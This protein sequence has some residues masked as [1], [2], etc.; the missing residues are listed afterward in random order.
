MI[1]QNKKLSSSQELS[2]RY[3]MNFIK[4]IPITLVKGEGTHVWDENGKEYIDFVGGWAVDSLGHCH[5]VMKKAIAEQANLLFQ[6]SNHY[7]TIPQAQLAEMLVKNSC[8]H[9]AFF[10]NS[11]TE[12][13]EGAVKLAR[14]YGKLHLGG[15][16]EVI[17]TFSS[18]HGRTLAMVAATGQ[19]K[20]QKPY[21]PLPSGFVNVKYDDIEAIK[22]A[23]T[24]NTCGVM[25]EPVQG[26]GGVNIPSEKYIKEVRAWCDEKDLLLI[27]DEVQ[28]GLG[29]LGALFGYQLFGIE[30]D[31]VTLAKSLGSGIPIGAFLAKEKACVFVPGDHGTTYGGNPFCCAVGVAVLKHII[32]ND[33]PGHVMKMGAHVMTG[34]EK[35]K[36]KYN[37]ITDVRGKGLLIALEFN[38]DI[39]EDVLYGCLAKGLLINM[40]K[41]NVLRIIPPLIIEKPDIDKGMKILDEVLSTMVV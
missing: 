1:M 34:L 21:S 9:Q 36:A 33:I 11:G 25:L 8:F 4:R 32:D 7:Y 10:S 20:M 3:I 17:T 22:K 13:N 23:T 24:P 37:F 15:A 5:P 12:A 30:P 27:F 6:V 39:S 2:Q 14:R 35:I 28:T 38:K 26:E 29:R 18:F 41:P 40:I 31:I 19:E 16:Y